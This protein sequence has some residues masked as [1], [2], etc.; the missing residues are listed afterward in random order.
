MPHTSKL[1]TLR[2]AAGIS[3]EHLGKLI[4]EEGTNTRT[5]QPRI[6]SYE[7]GNKTPS[8]VVAKR[9]VKELNKALKAKGSKRRAKIEDVIYAP[10]KR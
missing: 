4:A 8:V 10:A 5:F 7:L 3:Q 1:A 6:S 2:E 9:L